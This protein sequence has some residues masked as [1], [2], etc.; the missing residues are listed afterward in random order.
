MYQSIFILLGIADYNK[1]NPHNPNTISK[2]IKNIKMLNGPIPSIQKLRYDQEPNCDNP[3]KLILLVKPWN[4]IGNRWGRTPTLSGGAPH[5]TMC[6]CLH[7]R[8]D[9][10]CSLILSSIHCR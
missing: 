9:V 4:S 3:Y 2:N 5:F 1:K 6:L 10:S 7:S 8:K